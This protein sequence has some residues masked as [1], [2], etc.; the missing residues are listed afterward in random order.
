[1]CS[2][3]GCTWVP[4]AAGGDTCEGVMGQVSGTFKLMNAKQT[5]DKATQKENKK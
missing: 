5:K 3:A 2:T 4:R 1:M